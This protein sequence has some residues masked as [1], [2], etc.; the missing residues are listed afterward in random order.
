MSPTIGIYIESISLTNNMNI[1]LNK[2]QKKFLKPKKRGVIMILPRREGKT[3]ALALKVLDIVRQSPGS[4]N[5]IAFPSEGIKE[6]FQRVL[7]NLILDNSE[8]RFSIKASNRY[9]L[10]TAGSSQDTSFYLVTNL[11]RLCGQEPDN[12][13]IDEFDF[14][15]KSIRGGLTSVIGGSKYTTKPKVYAVTS[16]YDETPDLS[17]LLYNEETTKLI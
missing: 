13:L 7:D 12:V 5:I 9:S 15:D 8:F 3:T 17:W 16:K 14:I 10:T 11:L 4:L 2:Y 1:E 6:N